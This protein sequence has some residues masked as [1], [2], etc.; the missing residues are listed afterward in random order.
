MFEVTQKSR[1]TGGYNFHPSVE[2]CCSDAIV[3]KHA[4][5]FK[6]QIGLAVKFRLIFIDRLHH[7]IATK[8]QQM[9]SVAV[10]SALMFPLIC[11]NAVWFALTVLKE[12]PPLQ[13]CTAYFSRVSA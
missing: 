2:D 5:I 3:P 12:L 8:I 4:I 11:M 1:H 13:H 7:M 9:L 10:G 6:T